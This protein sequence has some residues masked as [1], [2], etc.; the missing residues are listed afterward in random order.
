MLTYGCPRAFDPCVVAVEHFASS[1][2]FRFAQ[3]SAKVVHDVDVVACVFAEDLSGLFSRA[4]IRGALR[5]R[6]VLF[7]NLRTHPSVTYV[8]PFTDDPLEAAFAV[9]HLTFVR[10]RRSQT[11]IALIVAQFCAGRILADYLTMSHAIRV[12]LRPIAV[13]PFRARLRVA[14]DSLY[15][16]VF[17]RASVL[18][19]F[20]EQISTANHSGHHSRVAFFRTLKQTNKNENRNNRETNTWLQALVI[21]L[22]W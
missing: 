13:V 19:F 14:L 9:A 4:A 22:N 20:S 3:V 11:L 10:V 7:K 6:V 17:L 15:G 12:A 8:A 16:F 5:N 21:Q 2:H 18:V 1:A